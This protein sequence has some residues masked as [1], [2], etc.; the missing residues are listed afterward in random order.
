MIRYISIVNAR[1]SEGNI[2]I[3]KLV[4]ACKFL[5]K[6]KIICKIILLYLYILLYLFKKSYNFYHIKIFTL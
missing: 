2:E 1:D 3:E 6:K 4:L 5:N